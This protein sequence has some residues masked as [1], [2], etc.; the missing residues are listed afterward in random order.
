[1]RHGG[2][3]DERIKNEAFH[4]EYI[5]KGSISVLL[6]DIKFWSL[7]FHY[8]SMTPLFE[9]NYFIIFILI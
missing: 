8:Q 1:M 4:L 2:D 6:V 9:V 7:P 3:G 5:M